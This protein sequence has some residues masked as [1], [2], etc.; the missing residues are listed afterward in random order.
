MFSALPPG[1]Q[2]LLQ[3][4][5]APRDLPV[6]CRP[7][8][9]LWVPEMAL[10]SSIAESQFRTPSLREIMEGE[11]LERLTW[12]FR[13]LAAA[14]AHVDAFAAWWLLPQCC[15]RM[16]LLLFFFPLIILLLELPVGS[17]SSSVS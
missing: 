9:N 14:A 1:F 5:R 6:L 11:E 12:K 16:A 2:Q 15:C 13:F 3:G 10:D 8:C 7:L 17:C 4:H